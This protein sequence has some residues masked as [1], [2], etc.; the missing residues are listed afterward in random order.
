MAVLTPH[1]DLP[2]RFNAVVEQ[3]TTEDL[4]NCVYT[5]IICP[6]GFRDMAPNFGTPDLTFSPLPVINDQVR[7]AIEEQEP[8]AQMLFSE[9]F[10]DNELHRVVRIAVDQRRSQ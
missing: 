6:L 8:R 1:F 9:Q 10:G 2:F 5:V 7:I 4:A 3:G